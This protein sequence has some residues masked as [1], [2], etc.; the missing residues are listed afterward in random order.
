MQ[1][2]IGGYSFQSNLLKLHPENPLIARSIEL[3]I[4]V[5]EL[6]SMSKVLKMPLEASLWV[7]HDIAMTTHT[8]FAVVT[9]SKQNTQIIAFSIK[10]GHIHC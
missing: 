5:I 1:S 7:I 9:V 10:T 2:D 3:D 8:L 4:E 6:K